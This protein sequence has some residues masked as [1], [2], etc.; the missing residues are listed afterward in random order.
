[1]NR[2][3]EFLIA[4]LVCFSLIFQTLASENVNVNNFSDVEK[5]VT[6]LGEKY[7]VKNVIVAFDIDCT[8]L[9]QADN[10]GGVI[11]YDWQSGLLKNDPDSPYLVSKDF[12]KMLYTQR[13]IMSF[14]KSYP[15]EADIPDIIRKLQKDGFTMIALTARGPEGRDLTEAQLNAYDFNFENDSFSKGF[16]SEY[17]P[18]IVNDPE[19]FG[20]TAEDVTNFNLPPQRAVSY[21]NGIMMVSGQ[22]KGIMLKTLIKKTVKTFKAVVLVD[23]GKKNTDNM[24]NV[25]KGSDID[26]NSY[27]YS[28]DDA[29][30][31]QFEQSNKNNVIKQWIEFKTSIETIFG[32]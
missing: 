20:L 19:K 12:G 18:Y 1:M 14:A 28:F 25:Y 32:N 22:N 21:S 16:P 3:S 13:M 10:F 8:L 9:T 5:K 24:Y 17:L 15:T 4:V 11:W 27:R 29:L 2:K 31:R 26:V 23:D 6:A 7:G 30:K